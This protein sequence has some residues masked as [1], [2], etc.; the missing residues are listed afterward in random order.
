MLFISL[1]A[2]PKPYDWTTDPK[3]LAWISVASLII[4]VLGIVV[5]VAIGYWFYRKG[6]N[7]HRVIYEVISD[8]PIVSVREQTGRGKIKVTYEASGGQVQPH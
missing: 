8:T 3:V 4:G 7:W 5:G 2:P 6:K 1:L